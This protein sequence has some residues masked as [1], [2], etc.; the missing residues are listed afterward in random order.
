M[1]EALK[2]VAARLHLLWVLFYL[3]IIGGA[4]VYA[5]NLYNEHDQDRLPSGYIELLV[6][7]TEYQLGEVV[8]FT[9]V[10][11]FPTTIY[12]TNHCPNEPLNVYRWENEAWVQ[13][14]AVAQND[15]VECPTQERN[16]AI[17][18]ESS[19]S[20]NFSDWPTLFAVPGVYRIAMVI[21]HYS[22]VPFQD[23]VVLEPAEEIEV[24]E[25]E[26]VQ[27]QVPLPVPVPAVPEVVEDEE[28]EREEEHE[29][30]EEEEHEDGEEDER[31]HEEED[32]D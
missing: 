29:N 12:V 4:V 17:P 19:R 32:D 21:D 16:V 18:T 31:G 8:E 25:A 1:F 10:N 7:K 26:R 14:H 2:I 9:V 15:E 20:Y 3:L 28:E 27:Q 13:L 11:H 23:F 5:N 30:E 22:D 24:M 6:N